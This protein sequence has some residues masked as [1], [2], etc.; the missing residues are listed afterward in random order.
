MHRSAA[1]DGT[2]TDFDY[3]GLAP[4]AEEC[5]RPYCINLFTVAG[6]E[7][8]RA[9]RMKERGEREERERGREEWVGG[10]AENIRVPFPGGRLFVRGLY[11]SRLQ[12][13]KCNLREGSRRAQKKK[14]KWKNGM[15]VEIE[16]KK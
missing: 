14:K 12:K 11:Q 10:A 13:G 15:G 2:Q 3:S 6:A 8:Q 9:M 16:N 4:K 7:R 5:A 1:K